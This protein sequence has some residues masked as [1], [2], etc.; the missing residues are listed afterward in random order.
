MLEHL[1]RINMLY[2]IYALLLTERQQ[3]ILRLYFSDNYSLGEI[4][5]EY[6][7]S[8]QAVHD[9]IKRALASIEK[10]EAKLGLYALFH[11][12]EELLREADLLLQ[13]AEP[14]KA[15]LERLKAIITELRSRNEQ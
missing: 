10:F 13:Q 2:D 8:R 15:D 4:A 14:G 7:I 3:E 11:Q 12:Q 9:L 5:A 6:Q 1:N